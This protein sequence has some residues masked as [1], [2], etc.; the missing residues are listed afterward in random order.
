MKT[1]ALISAGVCLVMLLAV[2][3]W[4]EEHV[5]KVKL[6][7]EPELEKL[8]PASVLLDGENAPVQKRNT[9]GAWME[10]GKLLVVALVDTSGFSHDYQQ[11]YA[12]VLLAQGQVKVG[13]SEVGPGF[14]GLGR[15]KTG[16]GEM[17]AQTFVLYDMGGNLVAE[18]PAMEHEGLRPATPIQL[19]T[20]EM[21]PVRLYLGL[22]FVTVAAG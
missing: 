3:A 5:G 17:Q 22:Y 8:V 10:N 18:I 16:E 13:D 14:Y 4:A 12:G 9:V 15:K 21:S 20:D 6:L 2:T 1:R 19:K 11:K 7:S